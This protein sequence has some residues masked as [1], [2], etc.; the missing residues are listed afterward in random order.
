[1]LYYVPEQSR[2]VTRD[3][4]AAAGL[5][6]VFDHD[7]PFSP[8]EVHGNGPDGGAGVIVAPADLSDAVRYDPDRQRWQQY[9]QTPCWIGRYRDREPAPAELARPTML[10][11][12]WVR[13]ANGSVWLVPVARGMAENDGSLE[14]YQA[15]PTSTTVDQAGRWNPGP[16][17]AR[18]EPLWRAALQWWDQIAV[19]RIVDT[20]SGGQMMLDYQGLHDAA[21]LALQANYRIGKGEVALLGL[22]DNRVVREVLNALVDWPRIE[23]ALKKKEDATSP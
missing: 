22:F 21:L 9:P 10:D 23:A 12:H 16:V 3:E 13:L 2:A 4:L 5:G 20:E 11:G 19:G 18:Y 17:V 6:H 14:W 8:C 15:L 7:A 1:M